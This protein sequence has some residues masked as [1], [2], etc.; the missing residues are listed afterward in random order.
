MSVFSRVEARLA[1]PVDVLADRSVLIGYSRA[2]YALRERTWRPDP[3]SGAL[4]GRT[5]IITGASSGIGEATALGLVRLGATAVLL[6]RDEERGQ[7]TRDRILAEVND[8]HVHVFR[9]DVSD[10]DDVA[11][12][13]ERLREEHP[14]IDVLVHNAGVL[15]P[16]R[17]ESPQ[18]HE[19]TLATHVLGPLRL[20][21]DLRPALDASGDA[22]VVWMSS[23]GMYTQPV[24][25]DDIEYRSGRY[26]GAVA[27]AR[28][29]R[30]QVA[31]TPLLGQRLAA[32]DVS[33]NA[34]HPGWVDT[35]GVAGSLP[36]FRA[37][38][39]PVLR[40]PEQGA[41]TAVWLAAAKPAP[42]CGRFW[43]DRRERPQHY[44][45]GRQDDPEQL[46]RAW[47]YCLAAA[48]LHDRAG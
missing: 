38:T 7:R 17:G 29:K 11:R 10:L 48:G 9:C 37:V 2:G 41:D 6:V 1:G 39:K 3:P 5:A 27:Y 13:A 21:E 35:P 44:L 20:T 30:L 45:P 26:R 16:A 43:H 32:E 42:V 36:G 25:A 19:L 18:G 40:T 31:F 12:G 24:P 23:G 4:R 47:A 33:V 14:T 28:T 46:H 22:R 8:A 34:T 15:P